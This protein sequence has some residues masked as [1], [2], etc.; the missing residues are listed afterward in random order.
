MHLAADAELL[1]KIKVSLAVVGGNVLQVALA[2]AYELQQPA[3]G[4]K[5]LL[6]HLK[7]FSQFLDALSRNT[8]L[9]SSAAGVGFGGLQFFDNCLFLLT[10]NHTQGIL[11]DQKGLRKVF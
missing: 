8:Y 11:P 1:D 7:V 2:L 10:C 4:S 9:Y 5:V 3:A 6:V